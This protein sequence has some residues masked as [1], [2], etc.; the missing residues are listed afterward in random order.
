MNQALAS[1]EDSAVM[2]EQPR[3]ALDSKL[4]VTFYVKAV[5]NNFKSDQ[6]N[7]PIYDEV[8]FV[9]IIIPGDTKSIIDT[10]VTMEHRQRFADRYERFKKNQAQAV[11]GTPLEVWP[12]MTVGQVAELKAM[13]IHTVEQLAELSDVLSQKIMGSHALRQKAAA[14]LAASSDTAASNKLAVELE[15]RDSEIEMLKAQMADLVNAKTKLV[16]K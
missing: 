12:Q 14:F 3:H 11:S 2:E 10:K 9:R 13:H 6:E 16:S 8:D 4:Y 7:R 5:K 1:Y 15:K